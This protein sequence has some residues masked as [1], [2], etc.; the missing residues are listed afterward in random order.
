MVCIKSILP[1]ASTIYIARTTFFLTLDSSTIFTDPT[2]KNRQG[3]DAG[4]QYA[5]WV[6]CGDDEQVKIANK[7]KDELQS[8]VSAGKVT[9]YSEANVSTDIGPAYEFYPAHAEHQEYLDKNPLGYCN[10]RFRFK[11]WPLLN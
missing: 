5:S 11:E 9:S 1:A 10:H 2:T 3:N 6:F 8:L 4:T 7:V